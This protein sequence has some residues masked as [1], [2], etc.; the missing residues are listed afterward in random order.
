MKRGDL[1]TVAM[2]GDNGKPRPAVVIQSDI[3]LATDGVLVLPLT[4]TLHPMPIYRIDVEPSPENGLRERSQIMLDR[5]GH[6][7]REK[8]GDVIGQLDPQT[9]QQL[10]RLLA[11]F[12]G[13]A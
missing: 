5:L 12:L 8:I 4:T 11:V 2:R 10:E 1:V 9:M 3:F 13:I 6:I 7:R